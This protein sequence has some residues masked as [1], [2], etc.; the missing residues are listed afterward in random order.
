MI[1]VAAVDPT[2][3]QTGADILFGNLSAP[4]MDILAERKR[5]ELFNAGVI[6]ATQWTEEEQA[7][8]QQRAQQPQQPDAATILAMAEQMQAETRA[9][10]EARKTEREDFKLVLAQQ[11]QQAELNMKAITDMANAL[12]TLKEAFGVQSIVTPEVAGVL[13]GQVDLVGRAQDGTAAAE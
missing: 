3:L 13:A 4:G 9:Q 2:V 5:A 6:P 1:E 10:S 11:K 12:K 8:M 7:E